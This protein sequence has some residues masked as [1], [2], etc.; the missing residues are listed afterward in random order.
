MEQTLKIE[1]NIP[2]PERTKR[3]CSSICADL[4]KKMKVGDSVLIADKQQSKRF[5]AALYNHGYKP[6]Q[7][8]TEGGTRFWK[9][10][11]GSS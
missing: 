3:G 5:R 8:K 10:D 9:M 7:R 2:I 6:V 1:S 4:I 11:K